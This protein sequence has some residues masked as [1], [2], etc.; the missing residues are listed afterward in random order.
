METKIKY[1]K[2][3]TLSSVLE[4]ETSSRQEIIRTKSQSSFD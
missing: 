4:M 1:Y 2:L 3:K